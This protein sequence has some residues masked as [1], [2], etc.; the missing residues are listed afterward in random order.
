MADGSNSP[1]DVPPGA[2]RIYFKF[3][4]AC[5]PDCPVEEVPQWGDT[6]TIGDIAPGTTQLAFAESAVRLVGP[7]FVETF[8]AANGAPRITKRE[9]DG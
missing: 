7:R 6:V 8:L 4:L 5:G 9:T 3:W 1:L 2:A